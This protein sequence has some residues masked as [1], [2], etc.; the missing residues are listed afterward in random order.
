MAIV[1]SGVFTGT[2]SSSNT[3]SYTGS[4]SV[5]VAGDLLICCVC[6]SDTVA[7]GTMSGTWTWNKLTSFTFNGGV[8]TVYIFYAYAESATLT[9]PV[10]DCTGDNAT[11]ACIHGS[12]LT[13]AYGVKSPSLRQYKTATGNTAN[14]SITLDYAPLST[15]ALLGVAVNKTNSATQW[16]APTSWF[17]RAE[18]SHAGPTTSFSVATRNSGETSSTLSW[19]NASTSNWGLIVLE[20]WADPMYK[21]IGGGQASSSPMFY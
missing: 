7:A 20:I 3:N 8:D 16:T 12:K 19:T 14:P 13:G 11:G 1:F 15:N 17:E 9:T 10:F 4:G 2:A 6:A 21:S 5:P 18:V